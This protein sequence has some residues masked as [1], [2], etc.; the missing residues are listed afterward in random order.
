MGTPSLLISIIAG[1]RTPFS[2]HWILLQDTP[3]I[4][5]VF[6]TSHLPVFSWPHV[7]V[8]CRASRD[9]AW[10]MFPYNTCFHH[11]QCKWIQEERKAQKLHP[12]AES[13]HMEDTYSTASRFTGVRHWYGGEKS[14]PAAFLEG[15][16]Q[17]TQPNI[18]HS[19]SMQHYIWPRPLLTYK[20]HLLHPKGD[21]PQSLIK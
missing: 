21:N 11:H 1:S 12:G 3:K 20:I 8:V 14:N 16:G 9:R 17:G 13:H 10:H 18:F 7:L 6:N 4:S 19:Y 2:R 5:V 15:G